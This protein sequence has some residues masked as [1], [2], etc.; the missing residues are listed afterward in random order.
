MS[1]YIIYLNMYCTRIY[2]SVFTTQHNTT[3]LV[4]LKRV[5]QKYLGCRKAGPNPMVQ[6]SGEEEE[7]IN[8]LLKYT[9]KVNI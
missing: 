8:N 4:K 9:H 7:D 5:H 6:M 2:V 3:Q 1:E